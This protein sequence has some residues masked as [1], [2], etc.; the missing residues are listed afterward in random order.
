VARI[1][2][3]HKIK[4]EETIEPLLGFIREGIV[5]PGPKGEL[6]VRI[7][8]TLAWDHAIHQVQK[9]LPE[10]IYTYPLT[11]RQYL[12]ALMSDVS[13]LKGQINS[14]SMELLLSGIV[15][16]THFIVVAQ[17]ITKEDLCHF[18]CR[19]A[20]FQCQCGQSAIVIDHGIPVLL[21]N[22]KFTCIL[23]QM[24]N[25]SG[26]DLNVMFASLVITPQT[27]GLDMNPDWPYLV[28]YFTLGYKNGM[29]KNLKV[30]HDTTSDKAKKT[31]RQEMLSKSLANEDAEV[32]KS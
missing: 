23:I 21:L 4:F 32:A 7:L 2:N 12:T 24:R 18:F 1:I 29:I 26:S 11:V 17:S 5:E 22:G 30:V 28:L 15:F 31:K 25:Y 6:T 9:H 14:D 16:F 13:Y 10:F 3:H 8:L 20:A 27:A 19:S